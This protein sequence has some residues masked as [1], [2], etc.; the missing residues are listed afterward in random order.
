MKKLKLKI[1]NIFSDYVGKWNEQSAET[2]TLLSYLT[3]T[4]QFLHILFVYF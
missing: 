2:L 1:L 4:I 3:Y